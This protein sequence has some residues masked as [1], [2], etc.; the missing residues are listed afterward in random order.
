MAEFDLVAMGGTFDIIHKGH[1]TL[2]SGAFSIS[3]K[4]IIGLT[5]DEMAT[6]KG[7][8]LQNNF[9]KRMETLEKIIE[10]NFPESLYQISKLDNDFGPAVLEKNV[11]ALVVSDETSNQGQILNDLR[12]QKN[13]PPVEVVVVPMVLAKDGQRIS[14]TRIKNQEI[15]LEGNLSSID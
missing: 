13:L 15:D 4:V 2:L 5:S 14:T 10:K 11:E 7:K 12:K 9:E 8:K 6:K 3:S 1:L